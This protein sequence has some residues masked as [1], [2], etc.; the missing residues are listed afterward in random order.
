[1]SVHDWLVPF[2]L[3][4]AMAAAAQ[5]ADT[6]PPYQNPKLP[7][8]KR[9]D[10]L[11]SRM[12][13]QEKVSQM[14]NQAPAIE[15]LGIPAYDWWN[16]ALHGVARNGVATVF[17]QAIGLAATWDTELHLKVATVISD[18]A[19]AKHHEAVRNGV[20][21]IY[22]G[23]TFWSPNINIFR[24]PRW[25]RGQET[26]GE[27]PCLTGRLGVAFVKGM[28]G[29]DRKYLKTVA[30][31]KHYAVHS[32][33]EPARHGFDVTVSEADLWNTY[34]PAF[35]ACV[36]EGK[37]ESI[38]C[39]YNAYAGKPCCTNARLQQEILRK[40]WGFKGYI[41]SDCD[42]VADVFTG[43]KA[44]SKP[45]EAAALSL[46]AGTDL[47]C[48]GTFGA[49][50]GA[51]SLGLISE[52]DIDVA[53][54]RLFT[55]R[56]R[57]GMFDP[58]EMVK[59]A[60]IPFSVNDAPEHDR[61]A[62]R[63]AQESIVLLKNEGPVLPLSKS[64]RRIAVIGPN[65]DDVEV[66]LGNYNGNPSHPVTVLKGIRDKAAAFGAE[67]TYARGCELASEAPDRARALELAREADAVILVLGIHPRLEGEE[68]D[69]R[70][71]GFAGGDR[72]TL[73]LPAAQQSLM[74][75]VVKTGRPV[76][77]VLMS[78]SA[79]SVN[80]A[81]RHVP[82][83]V[84]AW[85]PGQ[86]GGAAVAD[87]L[88]GDVNPSG[89]L[90][91]TFY[92]SVDDLPPFEDYSMAGRT[93]RYFRGTALYPFGHGL[94]Y[95]SFRYEGL[96][97]DKPAAAGKPVTATLKV[98]NAGK[99]AGAE[100]VQFY[101][102]PPDPE[103]DGLIKQLAAFTRVTLKPGQSSVVKVSLPESAFARY[104]EAAGSVT[105]APGEYEVQ[106]GASSAD[107]RLKGIVRK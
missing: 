41:V 55:A 93:Y 22:A 31:P 69:V 60:R 56:F 44:V 64:L 101:I 15:R 1:M 66:L 42:A 40:Q 86:Q 38:M 107:I 88:F 81:D 90:P 34:L 97:L 54:K 17:P 37:A 96:R 89:R 62:L 84:Q 79:L 9:V 78:G 72:L 77:L 92:R 45:E 67:V 24:D 14:L 85:Y 91:V 25:G 75:D 4:F 71:P 68:M 63:A 82:A 80:W 103:V 50:P 52:Q 10:D 21:R 106:V 2:L 70:V 73:D 74:E 11:V 53:V 27:D 35:E 87:I 32:G 5:A 98:T 58:P 76:V 59:W 94:S 51:V 61:L 49:L 104:H 12:T 102:V 65:A 18:E 48:G 3:L 16:E 95:T 83:I 30:T 13:L 26:Y 28:Q 19:R 99:V 39:A 36:R 105:V 23:L 8:G 20:H 57:L 33:P 43:H 6:P 47:N 100:V 46:K 29:N 7:V